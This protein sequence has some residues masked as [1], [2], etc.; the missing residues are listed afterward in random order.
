[1]DLSKFSAAPFDHRPI[2]FRIRK[3]GEPP[4]L[5]NLLDVPAVATYWRKAL[6]SRTKGSP[7]PVR[8]VVSGHEGD[9][10]TLRGP[11][12]AL[13]PLGVV[14]HPQA[15]GRLVGLA[16]ALP[17]GLDPEVREG[18]LEVLDRVEEL[19]LGRPGKTVFRLTQDDFGDGEVEKQL[20]AKKALNI[21]FPKE[22]D[23]L[24]EKLTKQAWTLADEGKSRV[25]VLVYAGSREIA[26]KAKEEVERLAKGDKKVGNSPVQ[27]ETELFVGGRRVFECKAAK[28]RPKSLGFITG[29]AAERKCLVFLFAT[30][31][32][33]VGVD[34]EADHMVCDLVAWE[35][36]VQRLGR[37]NWRGYGQ[38]NILVI[39][40]RA[41]KK[42]RQTL[43]KKKRGESLS[44]R[45][46]KKVDKVR[47]L[48]RVRH[49]IERLPQY[50][51]GA[52]DASPGVLRDL[53][54][55]AATEGKPQ[56]IHEDATAAEP[57]RP[58][59]THPLVE[60]WA[61]TSLEKHSGRPAI[62]LWLRGWI[63]ND[64]P[65]TAVVWRTHLPVRKGVSKPGKKEIEAFFEAAPS[66]TGEI[67]ET[68]TFRAF[69]G[70]LGLMGAR[71]IGG[72]PVGGR[73]ADAFIHRGISV[74]GPRN[75]PGRV[76]G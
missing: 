4:F 55:R 43:E 11:H 19:R 22:R 76:R 46:C 66:H 36:M 29:T 13:M 71:L 70:S 8:R 57:L 2:I 15:D 72:A 37:V 32:G 73:S 56:K 38:A 47:C 7:E 25:R 21:E 50:G 69:A 26:R 52:Y 65:Q 28:A 48:R 75:R 12:L 74:A 1:M 20:N 68:E 24:A 34:L 53:K 30:S 27:I 40:P 39:E 35:Q 51:D 18:V 33:G 14:G 67:L 23:N 9:G 62:Q 10:A 42:I 61:R 3:K 5:L 44:E 64:P 49:L 16:A 54:T 31:S 45:D 60:A 41:D 58:A 59:L 17:S 63:E 6:I